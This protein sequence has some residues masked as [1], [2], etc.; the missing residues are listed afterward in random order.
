[1]ILTYTYIYVLLFKLTS[2]LLSS[3]FFFNDTATTEIYTLSLHDA[4]PISGGG[5]ARA[6]PRR[7]RGGG[8]RLHRQPGGARG[9]RA[10]RRHV[11][12]RLLRGRGQHDDLRRQPG[13][14]PQ[15]AHD[16]GLVDLQRRRPGGVRALHRRPPHP[17]AEAPDPPL[18]AG[19]GGGGLRALRHAD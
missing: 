13:P 9:R 15:A 17:A 6:D 12:P 7:G 16:P 19:G 4:L 10:E 8:A 1:M 11:G 14:D 2:L 3:F 5:A 18:Q